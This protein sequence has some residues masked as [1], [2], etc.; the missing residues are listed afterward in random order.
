MN[1]KRLCHFIALAALRVNL[2]A[3]AFS[4]SIQSLEQRRVGGVAVFDGCEY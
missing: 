3:A 2:G 1:I 4:R